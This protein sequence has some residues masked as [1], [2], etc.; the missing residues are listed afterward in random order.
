MEDWRA[1]RRGPPMRSGA[2]DRRSRDGPAGFLGHASSDAFRT[3]LIDM[4][5]FWLELAGRLASPS[6]LGIEAFLYW[7]A[8]RRRARIG[9]ADPVVANRFLLWTVASATGL[10]CL[11]TSVPPHYLPAHHWL[12][13]LDLFVFSAAGIATAAAY[14]LAFFPPGRYRRWLEAP[15]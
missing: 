15:A 13:E 6:W 8:M 4:R 7:N 11:L 2:S 14:W 9:L 3:A 12:L 1:A 10:L 5:W